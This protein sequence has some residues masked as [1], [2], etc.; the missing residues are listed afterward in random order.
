M[1]TVKNVMNWACIRT[2]AL[3]CDG[4]D[5]S[6]WKR[7]GRMLVRDGGFGLE[8]VTN[9]ISLSGN[10]DTNSTDNRA[11]DGPRLKGKCRPSSQMSAM[12]ADV[13]LFGCIVGSSDRAEAVVRS[14]EVRST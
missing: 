1:I 13:F 9:P 3:V 5:D 12:M 14:F 10:E 2:Y 11:S 6:K 8:S 7:G 4:D